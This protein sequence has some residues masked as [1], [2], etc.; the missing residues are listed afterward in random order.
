M[1]SFDAVLYKQNLEFKM[2]LI[3]R[4]IGA[5]ENRLAK[6]TED[7]SSNFPLIGTVQIPTNKRPLSSKSRSNKSKD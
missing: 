3:D 4:K 1:N 5:I 2:N 7:K 6:M